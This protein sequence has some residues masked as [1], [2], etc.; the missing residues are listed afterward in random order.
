MKQ[1]ETSN[2]LKWKRTKWRNSLLQKAHTLLNMNWINSEAVKGGY[3]LLWEVSLVF[4]ATNLKILQH[5]IR[6]SKSSTINKRCRKWKYYL[7]QTNG[8][9]NLSPG[10]LIV[11]MATVFDAMNLDINLL[12]VN[13]VKRREQN[14]IH[15]PNLT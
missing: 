10:T 7:K 15:Q 3:F 4:P 13:C 12:N 11:S 14:A 8:K 9:D 2:N 1:T 6:Q 5:T